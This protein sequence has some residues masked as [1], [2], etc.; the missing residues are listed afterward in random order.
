MPAMV[1]G[2]AKYRYSVAL[3]D[4]LNPKGRGVLT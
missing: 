3:V 2:D 1:Q 4:S